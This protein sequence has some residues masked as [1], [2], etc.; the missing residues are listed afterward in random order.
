MKYVDEFRAGDLAHGL[1]AAIAREADPSH[2][3]N[4]MEFCG[5]HT[6]A[7]F[8]YGV[9]DLMP[10]NLRFVHGPGC[11]VC[12]LPIGRVDN[13]LELAGDPRVT[14]CTYGDMMRVPATGGAA[15]S[16]NVEQ[17]RHLLRAVK[18]QRIK[19]GFFDVVR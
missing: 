9:Q 15:F 6:H 17:Y 13:A 2:T 5:G 11:P 19:I 1:A 8:R 7:I 18:H 3:Y 12:V 14:L 16:A 10:A 4:V